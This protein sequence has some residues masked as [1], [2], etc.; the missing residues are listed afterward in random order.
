MNKKSVWLT[1]VIVAS[2]ITCGGIWYTVSNAQGSSDKPVVQKPIDPQAK[3][4]EYINQPEP[5]YKGNKDMQEQLLAKKDEITTKIR[6]VDNQTISSTK[7]TTWGEYLQAE[8]G[9]VKHSEIDDNRLV[10]KVAIDCPDGI[11]TK[12]G[13]FL[14]ATMLLVMDAETGKLFEKVIDGERDWNTINPS[15]RSMG[16]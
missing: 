9:N 16:K 14:K 11:H 10:W 4:Q 15:I 6:L 12:G 7:L 13:T 1:A 3:T 2:F 5:I 8:G